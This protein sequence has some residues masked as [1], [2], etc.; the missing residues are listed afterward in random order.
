MPMDVLYVIHN[1]YSLVR[2][3]VTRMHIPDLDIGTECVSTHK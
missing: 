2:H 1:S 3:V